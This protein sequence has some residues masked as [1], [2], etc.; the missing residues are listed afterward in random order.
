MIKVGDKIPSTTFQVL[1]ENGI[2]HR[3]TDDLFSN[4]KVVIFGLPGAYT[5][6]CSAAHLPGYVVKVDELKSLG[7]DHVVCHSVN[8]AFV[9]NAWGVSQNADEL[10]MMADGNADFAKAT[11]LDID[12]AAPGFGIRVTRYAM[13][14]ENG[15]VSLLNVEEAGKFEVSNVETILAAL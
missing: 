7:V 9:M 1:G 13:I 11:G 5:P 3:E 15:V 2:E 10:I 4:K 8:D 6:T 14:V 12:L